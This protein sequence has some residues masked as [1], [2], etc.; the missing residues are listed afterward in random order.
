MFQQPQ[1]PMDLRRIFEGVDVD[2]SGRISA[3]ELQKALS[4]GTW[5]P[6]NPETCRL[7]ISMFDADNDGGINFGEFSALWNY[8]NEWSNCFRRFDRDNSGNIDK[9]ELSQ[10][11]YQF[12]NDY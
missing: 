12:S 6:F 10:A 9:G 7:M 8:I 3:D 4:N 2:R 11:L 5:L 1:P